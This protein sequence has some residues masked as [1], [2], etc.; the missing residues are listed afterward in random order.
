EVKASAFAALFG[1]LG[2]A[3][4]SVPAWQHVVWWLAIAT[5]V[6]GNLI[7]LAQ[8]TVKRMLAYSSIAHAGYLLVAVATGTSLGAAAFLFYLVAYTLMTLAAFAL[9]AA[10]GR[11]GE[12]DVLIDDLA[13]LGQERPWLAFA[14]AICMLSLLGFPGTA[15]FIGKWYILVAATTAGQNVLAAVVVLTS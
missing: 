12:R 13:G 11:N 4:G 7:A 6:G 10:K 8:R 3:F 1:V 5:M 14:L 15:G 9:L 2:E